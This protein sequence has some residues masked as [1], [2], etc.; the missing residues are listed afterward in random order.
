MRVMLS[1]FSY[2]WPLFYGV[3]FLIVEFWSVKSFAV[4]QHISLDANCSH[5]E[6]KL[7]ANPSTGF[8]WTLESYDTEHFVYL[9][10]NDVPA[11]TTRMG[12][13]G[14]RIFYFKQ[15]DKTMCPESTALRFSYGRAWEVDSSSSTDVTVKFH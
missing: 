3:C 1:G 8:R 14:T 10:T 9:E 13:P 15:K 12:A 11:A 5:F 2:R 7:P 6:V 4:P